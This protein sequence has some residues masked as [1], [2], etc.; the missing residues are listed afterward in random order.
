MGS[1]QEHEHKQDTLEWNKQIKRAINRYIHAKEP[2]CRQE[3]S[4][5]ILDLLDKQI[6]FKYELDAIILEREHIEFIEKMQKLL[7]GEVPNYTK[8]P[9]VWNEELSQALMNGELMRTV[10]LMQI[11]HKLSYPKS[12]KCISE[13]AEYIGKMNAVL[14]RIRRD[15]DRKE[16]NS[17]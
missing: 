5:E 7:N 15:I 11:G 17:R 2:I 16:E 13:N 8:P 4:L 1:I 9:I 10:G 6:S 12:V 14:T 3:E